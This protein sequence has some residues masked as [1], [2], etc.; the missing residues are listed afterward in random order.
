M[1]RE[2]DI[3]EALADYVTAGDD[4]IATGHGT[5]TLHAAPM[6]GALLPAPA[7]VR[8]RLEDKDGAIEEYE[9]AIT[10]RLMWRR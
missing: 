8:V 9:I 7:R 4:R 10:A 3:V 2:Q 6:R 1:S 5:M